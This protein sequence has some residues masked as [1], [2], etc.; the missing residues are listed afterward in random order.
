[1]VRHDLNRLTKRT[2]ERE[3]RWFYI[4]NVPVSESD[5]PSRYKRLVLDMDCVPLTS[6][7][8]TGYLLN[9]I[10]ITDFK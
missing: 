6:Y 8:Q 2:N 9:R 1:M 4:R 7:A 10:L 3:R 5:S